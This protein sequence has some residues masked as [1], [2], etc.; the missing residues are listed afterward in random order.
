MERPLISVVSPVYAAEAVVEQLVAEIIRAVTPITQQFEII[1]VEDRGPDNSWQKIRSLCAADSRVKGIRLSR[2]FG[3]HYAITAGLDKSRGEWVVVMD[4]DLQDRPDQ[5]VHFYNK[6]L[7]G[8]QVVQGRRVT[9]Q[10]NFFK[11]SFSWLFYKVLAYLSGY[12]QDSTIAN[13]GIYHRK[14]VDAVCSLREN[15][16]FFPTMVTWVGFKK[17]SI[18][19]EHAAR[20]VGRSSYNF[21]KLFNLALDIVLAYSD[22]PLRLITKLGL[23][24]SFCSLLIL[25][26]NVYKYLAGEIIVMGYASLIVSLWFLAGLIMFILGIVGL[27]VGKTFEGTKNR[28]IYIIEDHLNEQV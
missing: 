4:C 17:V 13:F 28:P 27:Y 21:S 3:Q 14:V 8:Y 19:I 22:K 1:L 10:D 15:I 26:Y 9:R 2:N 12:S 5:I 25:G 6:A 16:R 7:E 23:F 24:T 18:P 20:P 11:R